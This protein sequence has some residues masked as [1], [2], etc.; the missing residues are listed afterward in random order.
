MKIILISLLIIVIVFMSLV[1]LSTP[2][3]I[4]KIILITL[5]ALLLLVLKKYRVSNP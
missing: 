1:E 3:K 2:T 5:L 4:G